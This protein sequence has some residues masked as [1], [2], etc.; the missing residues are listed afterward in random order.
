MP[1]KSEK[2]RVQRNDIAIRFQYGRTYR[3]IRR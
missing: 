3:S 2:K 1:L